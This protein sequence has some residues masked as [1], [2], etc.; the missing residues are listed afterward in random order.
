MMHA[1]KTDPKTQD[2][3]RDLLTDGEEVKVHQTD[4]K[5]VDTDSDGLNDGDEVSI[6]SDPARATRLLT[7]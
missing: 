7:Q 1:C 3:D 4:P 5:R 6:G 2:T